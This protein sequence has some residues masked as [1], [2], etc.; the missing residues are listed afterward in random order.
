MKKIS[1]RFEKFILIGSSILMYPLIAPEQRATV[2]SGISMIR[3]II[4]VVINP[5]IG[6]MVD[7]N[8]GVTLGV[9]GMITVVVGLFMTPKDN[10]LTI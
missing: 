3:Q 4:L 7:I 9:L 5:L 8:L 2:L 6:F 10:E 1:K